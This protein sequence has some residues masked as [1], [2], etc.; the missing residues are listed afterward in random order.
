MKKV[1]VIAAVTV[2][3]AAAWAPPPQ[4]KVVAT[5]D[6]NF[7]YPFDG[8]IAPNGNVYIAE[9]MGCRIQ[10]F[11][12]TGSFLGSWGR[13]GTG[14]GEF[15]GICGICV[16]PNGNVYATDLVNCRVQYFNATGSYLGSWG[17][18]G[19]GNGQ[20]YWPYG[21]A[22]GPNGNVYVVDTYN[23]RIQYFTPTGT[24]L[25]KWGS[26]G[27][28]NGSFDY[29]FH[30][31]VRPNGDVY[32][33]DWYNNRVQY[34]N[35]TGSFGG[36]WDVGRPCGL[37]VA[38][39]GTVFVG[40]CRTYWVEYYTAAGSPLGSFGGFGSGLGSFNAPAGIAVTSDLRRV[41]V[42]D[43]RNQRIQYFDQTNPAV[44]PTSLGKVKALFR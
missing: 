12:P 37:D 9:E 1:L 6:S 15:N 24:F 3:A 10:Y 2:L 39:D 40:N 19:Y 16:V 23:Q 21:I 35:S 36:K 25:G 44:V 41:Y 20:F 18:T 43:N 27:K 4:Y 7:N 11:T 14:R 42:V 17:S 30:V 8:A 26:W 22:H 38:A 33:T 5:F 13:Y 32:V 29:P 31:A 34:F 28:A